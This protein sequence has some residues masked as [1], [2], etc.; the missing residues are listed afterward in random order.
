MATV[1]RVT[2]RTAMRH[3]AAPAQS[4]TQ[5]G[6]NQCFRARSVL[7]ILLEQA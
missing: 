7:V 2:N 3:F 6:K 1:T 5:R 4:G